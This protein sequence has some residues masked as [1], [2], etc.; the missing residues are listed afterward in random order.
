MG[1]KNSYLLTSHTGFDNSEYLHQ[2]HRRLTLPTVRYG[3]WRG[4]EDP[5]SAVELVVI[6]RF[7][8]TEKH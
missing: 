4:S 6:D 1:K 3:K 2:S 7:L 8:E 5:T